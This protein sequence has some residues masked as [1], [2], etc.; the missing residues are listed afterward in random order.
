MPDDVDFVIAG[1]RNNQSDG[2]EPEAKIR[3]IVSGIFNFE[4]N[5]EE[6]LLD[7]GVP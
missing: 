5:L 1:G 4:W 2:Q 7:I 3:E 6:T